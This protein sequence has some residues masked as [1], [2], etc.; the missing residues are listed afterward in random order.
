MK[1]LRVSERPAV[2]VGPD[3]ATP[4]ECADLAAIGGH[5]PLIDALDAETKHDQTGFS[6]ELPR[7]ADPLVEAMARRMEAAVGVAD[8]LGYSLRFRRYSPGESHPPHLDTY[9]FDDLTLVATA[10]L[11]LQGPAHGGET[12]FEHADSG[13]LDVRAVTGRLIAW[14]NHRPDGTPDEASLHEGLP[15]LAGQ[16]VTLTPFAYARDARH[17]LP[18]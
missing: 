18:D 5:W 16:K 7:D 13:G 9:A 4:D 12:R 8:A 14:A 2:V 10:L 1:L 3:F 6:W 15:V 11:I 17:A